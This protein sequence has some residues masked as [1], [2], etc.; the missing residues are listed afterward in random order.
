MQD[1]ESNFESKIIQ[2][3][4]QESEYLKNYYIG[5][6]HVFIGLTKVDVVTKTKSGIT[7]N[8]LAAVGVDSKEL[9]DAI[10]KDIVGSDWLRKTWE[11]ARMTPRLIDIIRLARSQSKKERADYISEIH[12]LKAILEEGKSVPLRILEEKF[13]IN[14]SMLHEK[15]EGQSFI[16]PSPLPDNFQQIKT[17]KNVLEMEK[18][19][20]TEIIGQARAVKAV[21][22]AIQVAMAGIKDPNKPIGVFLFL[23][24][25]GVGKTELPKQL[26]KFLFGSDNA[27]IRLDMS[28]FMQE[29]D[30][31]KLIGSPPGYV[32][33]NE[34]GQ[35]TRS[36]QEKPFSVVLLDEIEKAHPK[37]F[38]LLLQVFD[39]GRITD[40]KG[41]LVDACR[42]VFIMTSNIGADIFI[43]MAEN[44]EKIVNP[45]KEISA[46]SLKLLLIR[47][48][49]R[50]E[51]VNRIDDI[52]LF[53][54]LTPESIVSI[55]RKFL[56]QLVN[57]VKESKN[58][59]MEITPNAIRLI[60]Q[61]GFDLNFG[62]RPLK[63]V[64]KKEIEEPLSI[65]MLNKEIK[66]NDI[67]FIDVVND[68]ID[69]QKVDWE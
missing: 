15:L 23:G 26:A 47:H 18:F 14:L 53:Q 8:L 68:K 57:R 60:C 55:A 9:R 11:K 3:A 13:N 37:V 54:P 62:A 46:E 25:T 4:Q 69:L 36:L 64:I 27:T 49:F 39:E 59:Q 52:I 56:S 67:V 30:A 32:G 66:D 31:A 17:T 19:I 38:D 42:S 16:S 40:S 28:E 10:R 44:G 34:G 65:M 45:N 5:V 29:H 6:E 61:K 7:P 33:Y 51:F 24:P 22:R 21:S 20:A 1:G 12:I 35:L 50:P 2:Y 48:K 43:D 63:N 41:A 58:I